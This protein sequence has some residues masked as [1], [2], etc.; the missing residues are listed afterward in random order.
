MGYVILAKGDSKLFIKTALFFNA[1]MLIFNVL[2]YHFYGLEGLGISFFIYYI[3]HFFGIK[4]ITAKHYNLKLDKDLIGIFLVLFGL[5]TATFLA[6]YINQI[7]LKYVICS[8]IFIVTLIY[9]YRQLDKRI[10]FK[11][12]IRRIFKKSNE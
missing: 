4:I 7:A 6:T 10:N 11:M 12:L 9:S 3:V 1:L 5:S 2:G 8:L